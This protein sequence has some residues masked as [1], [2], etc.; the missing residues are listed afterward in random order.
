MTGIAIGSISAF[1]TMQVLVSIIFKWGSSG[2]KSLWLWSFIVANII[3]LISTWFLM[4]A[5][6]Y[7]NTN[8]TYGIGVG[9]TFILTQVALSLIFKS[10]MSMAQWA[11]LVV[12]AVCMALF[13]LLG[14]LAS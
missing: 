9:T 14:S 7:L 10:K 3:A 13:T 11:L 12:I 4:T 1:V 5:Y 8:I 6:K 2:S